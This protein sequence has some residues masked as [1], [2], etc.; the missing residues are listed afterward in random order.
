MVEETE[1]QKCELCTVTLLVRIDSFLTL[2]GGQADGLGVSDRWSPVPPLHT[3]DLP[4]QSPSLACGE[5]GGVPPSRSLSMKLV[6]FCFV[7]TKVAADIV[8]TG[9]TMVRASM[10]RD[11][12]QLFSVSRQGI[13]QRRPRLPWEGTA[14]REGSLPTTSH[15]QRGKKDRFHPDSHVGR[16]DGRTSW[17]G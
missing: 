2:S 15:Q 1:I 12:Q 7:G 8:L 5:R 10:W 11:V 14:H 9:P 16:E 3:P 6:S 13:H 17:P 4:N